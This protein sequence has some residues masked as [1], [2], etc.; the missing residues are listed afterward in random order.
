MA[1]AHGKHVY[2]DYIGYCRNDLH[3]GNWMLAVMEA[4]IERAGIRSVHSRVVE[5]DGSLSPKGFAAVVLLDESHVSAHC[6]YERGWL[7]VDAFTCGN[8]EPTLIADYIDEVL[9][10]DMPKITLMRR[11]IVDRFLHENVEEV[12]G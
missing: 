10:N 8:G 6:Y 12:E 5:F 7:A 2:I 3:D 11:D 1:K 4:A 9:H